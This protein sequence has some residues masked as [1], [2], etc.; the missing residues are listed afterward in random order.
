[1]KKYPGELEYVQPCQETVTFGRLSYALIDSPSDAWYWA[2]VR[3]YRGSQEYGDILFGFWEDSL[4][5]REQV[6]T[7]LLS[8]QGKLK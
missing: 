7:I 3:D 4:P 6:E 2:I 5:T 1:M 8:L